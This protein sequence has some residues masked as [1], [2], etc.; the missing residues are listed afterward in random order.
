MNRQSA[1]PNNGGV[2]PSIF[3]LAQNRGSLK[4]FLIVNIPAGSQCIISTIA[5]WKSKISD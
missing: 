3:Q 5:K 1:P 4:T 2:H